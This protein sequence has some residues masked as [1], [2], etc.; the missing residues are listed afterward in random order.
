MNLFNY[1]IIFVSIL[2]IGCTSE[3]STNDL[4]NIKSNEGS[5]NITQ[6]KKLNK[7]IQ[8]LMIDVLPFAE[9]DE[10]LTNHVFKELCKLHPN[11]KLLKPVPLFKRAYVE[12]LNRYVADTLIFI[13]KGQTK[14]GHVT[15]GLTD[16]DICSEKDNNK[17]YRIMGY[18]YEP[19]KSCVVSTTR[20][21]K[22]NLKEQFFKVAIH[23][24]GHTHGLKHCSDKKCLMT[25]AEGKNNT[26]KEQGFCKKCKAILVAQGW[27][28]KI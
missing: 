3:N 16:K 11:V 25:D 13:L 7:Q 4:K 10:E 20:L 2:F 15:I 21:S 22:S 23:E 6:Q 8:P 28:L 17:Y 5:K 12:S 24:L 18:G 26:D 27:K 19:G 1:L 9:I 14:N